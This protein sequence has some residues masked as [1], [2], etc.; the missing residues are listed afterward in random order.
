MVNSVN[1]VPQLVNSPNPVGLKTWLNLVR[2]ICPVG[3]VG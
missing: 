1:F 2:H 3:V